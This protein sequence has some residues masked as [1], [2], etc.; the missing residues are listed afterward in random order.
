M[1]GKVLT[2][3]SRLSRHRLL[4]YFFPPFVKKRRYKSRYRICVNKFIFL[5]MSYFDLIFMPA[6]Q[7][8]VQLLYGTIS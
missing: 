6:R 5:F 3:A 8:N 1:A 4:V 2:Y 7:N